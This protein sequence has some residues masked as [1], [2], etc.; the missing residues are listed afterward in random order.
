MLLQSGISLYIIYIIHRT[1]E[2]KLTWSGISNYRFIYNT[3][4]RI[5]LYS[6]QLIL[7]QL[8]LQRYINITTR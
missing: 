4:A 1:N 3:A 2:S 7:Q 5:L 6:W 8:I